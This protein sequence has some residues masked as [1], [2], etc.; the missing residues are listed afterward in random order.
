MKKLFSA[1]NLFWLLLLFFVIT[2]VA[3]YSESLG[4]SAVDFISKFSL[5]VTCGLIGFAMYKVGGGVSRSF[6]SQLPLEAEADIIE[7]KR[8]LP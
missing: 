6:K 7:L 5:A 8:R 1:K 3:A 4:R 2:G